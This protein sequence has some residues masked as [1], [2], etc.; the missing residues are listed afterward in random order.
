MPGGWRPTGE[1]REVDLEVVASEAPAR[2]RPRPGR[3]AVVVLVA[4]V[5]AAGCGGR[6][7]SARRTTASSR[8]TT[9]RPS[10]ANTSAPT[11]VS[12]PA[13]APVVT[14]LDTI[15]TGPVRATPV[16]TARQEPCR[17]LTGA[18]GVGGCGVVDTGAAT[19]VW[20]A[21]KQDSPDPTTVV[22]Y[23]ADGG[24][25]VPVLELADDLRADYEPATVKV[26]DIDGRPGDEIVVGLR[27]IGTGGFLQLD[28]VGAEGVVVAH[29]TLDQGRA[30]LDPPG[31]VEWSAQYG[32][33]DPNCCPSSYLRSRLVRQGG[34][35]REVAEATVATAAVPAGQFP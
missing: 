23:R 34:R 26:A 19:L 3:G 21:S 29:R 1:S 20:F 6:D 35:W 25:L 8:P 10:T 15:L 14:D 5:A 30:E 24:R 27:N 11:A 12:V 17:A 18:A 31:I 13:G 9:S 4:V 33:D 28:V 16:E 2:R 7:G 22:I 32:P